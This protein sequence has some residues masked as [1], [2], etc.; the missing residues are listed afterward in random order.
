MMIFSVKKTVVNR[1]LNFGLR[2][3][4]MMCRFFLLVLLARLIEPHELGLF[5]LLAAT[6]AFSLYFLGFD[7]YIHTARELVRHSRAEWGG[8][9]KSQM[10]LTGLT[11]LLAAP[12]FVFL[13]LEGI[14]PLFLAPWLAVLMVLEH[15]NQELC[16]FFI[17]IGSPIIA[18]VILFMRSGI[19]V[20]PLF[21]LL[22]LGAESLRLESIFFYW[23]C[24]GLLG[25]GFGAGCLYKM[26]FGGWSKHID[27]YWIFRGLKIA[28]PF[29]AGTLCLRAIFTLDRYVFE[30]YLGLDTLAAYVLF[31]GVAATLNSF[32]DAGVFAFLYPALVKYWGSNSPE[33]FKSNGRAMLVQVIIVCLVFSMVALLMLPFLLGW[34]DN[35]VYADNKNLFYWL[36]IA[37]NL[38]VL[39]MVPHYSLYAQGLDKVIQLGHFASLAAFVFTVFIVGVFDKFISVPVALCV[40]FFML[41]FF[42]SVACM[43]LTPADYKWFSSK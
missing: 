23:A 36:L 2:A 37:M 20:L 7:F 11:Y 16:R 43:L 39:S 21:V 24:G 19:W 32:L 28:L 38:F 6:I 3:L 27:W 17:A 30:A 33:N 13:F 35:D 34:L 10:A 40:T 22:L 4:T 12:V 31:F 26:G 15:I 29:L 18:S 8:L 5:G 9:V 41:L 42:K 1:L 25:A 14:L